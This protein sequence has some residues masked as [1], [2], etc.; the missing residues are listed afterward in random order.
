M[1]K[2][3][4]QWKD[5]DYAYEDELPQGEQREEE[6]KKLRKLGVGEYLLVYFDTD[7]MTA[8]VRGNNV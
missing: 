7:A 5:P 4:F 3:L 1:P 6:L 2:Y 8:I